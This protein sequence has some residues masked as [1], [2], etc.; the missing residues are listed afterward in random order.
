M[1]E[2]KN[3][4]AGYGKARIL[5]SVSLGVER[6]ELVGVIG[7]NGSGKS[8]L[9]KSVIG[10]SSILGGDVTIDGK[11][12]LTMK[13]IERA[14][15]VS[16]LSQGRALSDM[17]V[18][19]TVLSGRFSHLSF[20]RRYGERDARIAQDAMRRVGIEDLADKKMSLLSG[21]MRQRAYIAMALAQ[22]T[23]YI[24]LDEPMTYLDIKNQ[25][26]LMRLLRELTGEGRGV[27]AVMHDLTLAFSFCD[28]IIVLNDGRIRAE[29]TPSELC[30][31]EELKKSFGIA[32]MKTECGYSYS[33]ISDF[34]VKNEV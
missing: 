18:Y 30:H 32:L 16:Y 20:P 10:I 33:S 29:G 5:H 6:G 4:S 7:A 19:D 27:C 15:L 31:S 23:D 13:S 2:I 17:S 22:D 21:G 9:L 26:S 1:L 34:E 3:L 28:R 14:R 12:A 8:T 24:L 11:S 25:L